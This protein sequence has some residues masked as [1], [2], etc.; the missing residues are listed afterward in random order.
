[1][2]DYQKTLSS[3][4]QDTQY[5]LQKMKQFMQETNAFFFTFDDLMKK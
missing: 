1:M 5:K 3:K 2:L 4:H